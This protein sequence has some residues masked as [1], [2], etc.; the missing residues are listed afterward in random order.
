M[1]KIYGRD[2]KK[3]R[4]MR[5]FADLVHCSSAFS[6]LHRPLHELLSGSI[7]TEFVPR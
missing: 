7:H 3:V 1:K 6:K 4:D 5:F 2:Y